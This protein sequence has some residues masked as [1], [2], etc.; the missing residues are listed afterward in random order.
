[1]GIHHRVSLLIWNSVSGKKNVWE[2]DV[3]SEE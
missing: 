2:G 1:M 3:K